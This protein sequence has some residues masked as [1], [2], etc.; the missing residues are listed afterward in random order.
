MMTRICR[1]FV[2]N[3]FAFVC[4]QAN[5]GRDVPFIIVKMTLYEG[6]SDLY[7]EWRCRRL[8][9][10]SFAASGPRTQ[11]TSVEAASVGFFSGMLAATV[12][13]PM[14]LV[15]TRMKS[16]EFGTV[17]VAA[18]LVKIFQEGGWR[19]YFKGVWHR[20]MITGCGSTVFWAVYTQLQAHIIPNTK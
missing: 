2:M 10:P 8:S 18:A 13:A 15:N 1:L 14:D 12:T 11:L 6:L 4:R 9:W 19:A 3:C 7:L 5:L 20:I 16:G 17:N